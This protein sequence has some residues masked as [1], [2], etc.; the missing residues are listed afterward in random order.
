M[1]GADAGWQRNGI[2]VAK[3]SA[4]PLKDDVLLNLWMQAEVNGAPAGGGF[5]EAALGMIRGE[6]NAEGDLD[7]GNAAGRFGAHDFANLDGDF[8]RIDFVPPGDD[9]KNGQHACAEGSGGEIGGGETLSFAFVVHRS[10]G[11]DFHTGGTVNCLASQ[12]TQVANI[13]FNHDSYSMPGFCRTRNFFLRGF[14]AER[15][16]NSLEKKKFSFQGLRKMNLPANV[17]FH[18][19]I[20]KF[21][22]LFSQIFT[23][24]INLY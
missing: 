12:I 4:H 24:W 1:R 9:T 21:P 22:L 16:E 11:N 19:G 14:L 13:D 18:A 8:A 10:I 20:R 15:P 7:A 2:P 23:V 5:Q 17:H 3:Q 6:G